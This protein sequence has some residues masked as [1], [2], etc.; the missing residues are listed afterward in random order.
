MSIINNFATL[1]E[2]IA[3]TPI[4]R[5]LITGGFCFAFT[6]MGSIPIL[7]DRTSKNNLYTYG[8]GFSAGVMLAASFISLLLPSMEQG[9]L[10]PAVSGLLL[11][12]VTIYF[13]NNLVP[14]EH[15]LKGYEGGEIFRRKLKTAW[16]IALAM[17]IHNIP[18]GFA[19]GALTYY[20]FVDGLLL[21]VAIGLQNIPEGM[22]V[23]LPF[24]AIG[25]GMVQAIKLVLISAIIE[26]LAALLAVVFSMISTGII[27]YTLSFAAGAMIYVVSHEVIPET[28]SERREI[29]A[30]IG[31]IIGVAVI[32]ILDTI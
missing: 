25:V 29:K 11:G 7:L 15:L 26:P 4:E 10:V 27:P 16:L 20:S 12:F 13:V 31:L 17:I 19:V 5:A 28:H 2:S 14:H 9:G 8:M 23:A 6:I 22:A 21:A 1:L 3:K 32:A 24:K 18:E 30:T